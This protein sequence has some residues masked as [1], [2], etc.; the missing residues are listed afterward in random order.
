MARR[1]L[2]PRRVADLLFGGGG[3]MILGGSHREIISLM[4]SIIMLAKQWQ[5][6]TAIGTGTTPPES[7]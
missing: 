4:R 5:A 7:A 1:R 6:P 2:L 3:P